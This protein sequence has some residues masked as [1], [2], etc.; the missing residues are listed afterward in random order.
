MGIIVD[1]LA[2]L[3]LAM[4]FWGLYQ[5]FP[6]LAFIV[7]GSTLVLFS[8]LIAWRVTKGMKEEEK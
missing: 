1:I 6:P 2:V 3:G 8:A 7:V 4:L 5:I